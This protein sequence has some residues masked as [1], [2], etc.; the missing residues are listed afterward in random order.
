[1]DF[2]KENYISLMIATGG[3]SLILGYAQKIPSA[4]FGF[5]KRYTTTTI[6][7]NEWEKVYYETLEFLTSKYEKKNFRTFRLTSQSFGKNKARNKNK[8]TFTLGVGVHLIFYKKTPT[9]IYL[10]SHS[11]EMTAYERENLYITMFTRKKQKVLD[12]IDEIAK[13]NE[14]EGTF[15]VYVSEGRI[16][17][18]CKRL[19]NRDFKTILIKDKNFEIIKKALDNF[20]SKEEWY[21]E[22]GLPYQLGMM[23]YGAPGSGKSSIIHAIA[24]YLNYPLYYLSPENIADISNLMYELPEKC[25]LVMEDIDSNEM[26]HDRVDDKETITFDNGNNN[27]NNKKPQ[28]VSLS[29]V[30]NSL[31]GLISNH[32]RILLATTNHIEKLD[33]AVT[34]EGRFDIKIELNYADD[35]IFKQFVNNFYPERLKDIENISIKEDVTTAKLLNFVLREKTFEEILEMVEDK[36]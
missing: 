27:N 30:L 11:S 16:W 5:F 3:L 22:N 8:P 10:E 18:F 14:E 36:K 24:S 15:E 26:L 34:R 9:L 35:E 23:L 4:L 20:V 19:R 21:L 28:P 12:F 17:K 13:Y 7:I 31:D 32:G 29:T 33:A 25:L 1:M 6:K 2:L